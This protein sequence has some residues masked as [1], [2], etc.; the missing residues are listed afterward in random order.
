MAVLLKHLDIGE[1][2]GAAGGDPWQLD[3]TMQ[4]GSPGE[5][6]ELATA[7]YEAGVCTQETSEEFNVAKQRFESAWDRQDGGD[8]PINDSDEVRR[9]TESLHLNKEQM[10][11]IGVD[12]QNISASLAE[13][14]RSGETSIGNLEA[15]L[16]IIDDQI[17][18]EIATAAAN[19]Q[20]VDWSELKEAAIDAT[21][22]ALQEE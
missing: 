17:D 15:R 2:T 5:I 14:Q 16:Q 10:S 7:F 1:L 4:S 11:R 3:K 22:Q 12:L 18:R 13:A 21:R 6:S 9:A 20:D 8:H 19:G